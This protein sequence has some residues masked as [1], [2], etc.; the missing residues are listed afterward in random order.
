MTLS[1]GLSP[2]G[3]WHGGGPGHTF[4]ISFLPVVFSSLSEACFFLLFSVEFLSSRDCDRTGT[5]RGPWVSCD[6]RVSALWGRRQLPDF[7]SLLD[8]DSVPHTRA[9]PVSASAVLRREA[10][11]WDAQLP[12]T[13][14][15][16]ADGG[17]LSHSCVMEFMSHSQAGLSRGSPAVQTTV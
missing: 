15:S 12:L 7:A 16:V 14:S 2:F 8:G 10:M 6:S 9:G 5:G 11:L 13:G 1:C 4:Q 17:H 3:G